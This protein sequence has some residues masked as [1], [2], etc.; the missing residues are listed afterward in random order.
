MDDGMCR[1]TAGDNQWPMNEMIN[2]TPI[3]DKS[4]KSVYVLAAQK[5]KIC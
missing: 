1:Q 4:E 5:C 3:I 2:T